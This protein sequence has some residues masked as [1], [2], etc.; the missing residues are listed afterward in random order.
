M[1]IYVPAKGTQTARLMIIYEAPTY[2]DVS[3]L[4]PMAGSV[5]REFDRILS[6]CHISRSDLWI[7]FVSKFHVPFS[8]GKKKESFITRCENA[9]VNYQEQVDDLRREIQSI[10]PNCILCL[11][12]TALY[13]LTGKKPL[14]DYR[15]SILTSWLGK[16][17][18][19]TYY[20]GAFL[21]QSESR[22]K[23]YWK[24]TI[25]I[26]DFKRALEESAFP[27]LRLP[28]RT[29]HIA[30][31]S[32]DLYNFIESYPS[33]KY[34]K[35]A[36]DIEARECVPICLGISFDP[37]EGMTVPLWQSVND[38]S[39]A[40]NWIQ[41]AH[42][43]SDPKRLKIG[44]NFKYDE[45][46]I[47]RLGLPINHLHSDTMLKSFVINPEL[48]KNLAFNTSIYTK[49]P[50]YK[51]E[52]MYEG[53]EQDLFLG[54]SRDSCV[55]LEVDNAQ[56]SDVTELGL[57]D[58]YYNFIMELHP[59]YLDI[60]NNGFNVNT[61]KRDELLREY[62][63]WDERLRFDLFKL[64]GDYINVNSWKQVSLLL[65]ETLKI[66]YRVGT[67]E[68]V[69]TQLLNNVVKDKEK[70]QVIDNIL[71]SRRVRRT[72]SN[73]LTAIR[74]YDGKMRT[75][76]FVC[77][78][79]GRSSTG[80]Q[81]PPIRPTED[82][83]ELDDK[84]KKKKKKK[85]LG[86]P[87]QVMTKHGDI[88]PKTRSMYEPEPGYI[89]LQADSSQAEA[90]VIFLLAEDYNALEDI[91]RHD[92]HA[93]TASWFFGGTEADYSKK[94]L[95]YESPIRFAGK[96]LRHAGHLGA[97]KRR[98]A[99]EINTQARKY[100]INYSISEAEAD[101]A[102]KIFHK[103]QP[104]IKEIFQQGVIKALEKKRQL[105]APVPVGVNASIGGIR[106]FYERWGDELFRQAFSYIPQRTVSEN[107]KGAAIRILKQAPWI[108]IIVEAHDALL[109]S[110]PIER[111]LEAA[112][113]LRSE[114][115]KPIQFDKCSLQRGPLVIPCDVEVGSN[116]YEMSKFKWL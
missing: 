97:S 41:L 4:E 71:E 53:S 90:R 26:F 66:P 61:A 28:P 29:L 63:N 23:D 14:D 52:G 64:T 67:G 16:K 80:M 99:I 92:Y 107:T 42:I 35:V 78:D 55:T 51:N 17:V 48:P 12:P 106:T 70:R 21:N 49:E 18:I 34:P 74:D 7:S 2:D 72:I 46:K 111:Q 109:V 36:E 82:I 101:K 96:T 57:T 45:D 86:T 59:L 44:Q 108:K 105:I 79:T 10:N 65:Y 60:E 22:E 19:A 84:G 81:E 114:F 15:G 76:Y 77:L 13:V 116:Y 75:T 87:F 6:S 43:N 88:G 9:G 30:R 32:S 11:G 50:F 24:R 83:I 5:G 85:A 40:S 27:D 91:D 68:E 8:F 62:I 112:T 38:S 89:F 102:L 73:N 20:P 56:E 115:E 100:K 113:L 95:G 104:K 3:A 94:I 37:R 69:L 1:S 110:V 25:C 103:K 58:F 98:A 93:L 54:C 47:A 31:N 33:D 39:L